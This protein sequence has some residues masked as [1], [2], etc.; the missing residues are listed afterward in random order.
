MQEKDNRALGSL[1]HQCYS[2]PDAKELAQINKSTT[3]HHQDPSFIFSQD[4]A[5]WAPYI[6]SLGQ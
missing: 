4:L 6:H 5:L 2:L 1:S 3:R